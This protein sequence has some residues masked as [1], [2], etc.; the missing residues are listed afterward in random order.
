M[1]GKRHPILRYLKARKTSLRSFAGSVGCSPGHL[2]EVSRGMARPSYELAVK[3]NEA[4][5]GKISV[6]EVMSW[7]RSA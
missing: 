7:P 3:L 2:S 6:Y 1:A 5:A 4:S